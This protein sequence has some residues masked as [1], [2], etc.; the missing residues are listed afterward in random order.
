M[1]FMAIDLGDKRT[2]L[3][4]GDSETRV[5][6]PLTV[7]D[8]AVNVAGGVAL[9]EAIARAVEQHLGPARPPGFAAANSPWR[10]ESPGE[11]VV[12]LPL[13][14]DGSEGPRAKVVRAFA[15]RIEQRTGRTVRFQD[16]RL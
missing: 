6:S 11:L 8:V 16:E 2:G 15:R 9:L 12:G 7:L 13:N 10:L 4:T 1:R 5:V 14:M 3:A